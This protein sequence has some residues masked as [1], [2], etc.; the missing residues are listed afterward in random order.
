MSAAIREHFRKQGEA[1][2]RLGSPFTKRVCDILADGLDDRTAIGRLVLN[3]PGKASDDA[4]ALRLCGAL[5]RL[6]LAGEDAQLVAVY[7]PN[8][9]DDAA[10]KDAVLAC[11]ERR[12]DWLVKAMSSPPQTNEIARSA[13]LLPGMLRIAGE[14]GLPLALTEIGAS[15]GLNQL[16]GW[17]GYRYGDGCW[18][19]PRSPVQL[20][21]E[22]RGDRQVPLD[23]DLR[24][25]SAKG[26]DIAPVDVAD[27]VQRLRLRS[28][29][30][31]DQTARLQRLDAAIGLAGHHP[32]SVESADAADFVRTSLEQPRDGEARVLF[33]SI[34]WQYMPVATREAIEATLR[35]L[36]ERATKESPLAWLRME[37]VST[38]EPFATLS[39]TMWPSGEELQLAR[40]DYHGRWIEWL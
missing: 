11:I 10:L 21:P 32:V 12:D 2:E 38:H 3:W 4:V 40:C 27:P 31:A 15:A 36:G 26:C 17:F 23:G 33:H 20:S 13:M 7:P 1:C 5:H 8:T 28:F 35:E 30:W 16:L 22:V 6:V 19:D 25:V 18:G 24:I 34:M 39:L 14:T 29:I 9:I 37:P